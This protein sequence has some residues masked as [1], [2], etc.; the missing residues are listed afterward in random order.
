ME[1][2]I[3]WYKAELNLAISVRK[4]TVSVARYLYWWWGVGIGGGVSRGR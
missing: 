1:E 2:D 3:N 4:G